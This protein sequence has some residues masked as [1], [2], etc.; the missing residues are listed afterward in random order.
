MNKD[1][2]LKTQAAAPYFLFMVILF[3]ASLIGVNQF[4]SRFSV[5]QAKISDASSKQQILQQKLLT[6]Q[7]LNR[8]ALS[9]SESAYLALPA[10]NPSLL[11]ISQIKRQAK[12]FDI[13]IDTLRISAS[14]AESKD[15]SNVRI[16]LKAIGSYTSIINF[17]KKLQNEAPIMNIDSLKIQENPPD[18]QAT[19]SLLSYWSTLPAQLPALTESVVGFS[20]DE[21]DTLNTLS[22]LETPL[23]T[24]DNV[25]TT[26]ATQTAAPRE[27]PFSVQ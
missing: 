16:D 8:D 18:F 14:S 6:L 27:N 24:Q 10:Y 11:D 7:Q 3:V 5:I 15:L 19:V 21:L 13:S 20:Q 12:N 1:F 17:L 9:F 4:Y 26:N 22:K 25:S 23:F 2:E